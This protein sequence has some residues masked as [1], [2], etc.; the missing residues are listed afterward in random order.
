MHELFSTLTQSV[1]LTGHIRD[2]M[3]AFLVRH[4]YPKTVGHSIHVA[5]EA[6]RLA[7]IFGADERL[8]EIAGWLHD[9]SVVVPNPQRSDLARAVGLAVLPEEEAVPMI[10]HQKLSA[11]MAR[12]IFGVA[13]ATVLSA[14]RCHTTLKADA[15]LLDKVVFVADKIKWDQPGE[16]PYLADLGAALEQS[17]DWAAFCYLDYLWQRRE[18]LPVVHPWL[19]EAHRQ[20]SRKIS[21]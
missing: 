11:L 17:L 1:Q 3:A 2:D 13:E 16:P 18:T 7:G 21:W 9:I 10:L 14:I 8:A 20:L 6:R 19:A 15:S 4:G 5:A 12:D